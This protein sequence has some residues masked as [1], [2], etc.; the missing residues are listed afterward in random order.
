MNL[1]TKLAEKPIKAKRKRIINA[2]ECEHEL[3]DVLIILFDVFHQAV[4]K[5]NKEIQ[6]TPP[7]ARP[8]GFEAGLLN[9]KFVQCMQNS[10][11]EDWRR[12]K[13]G[14]IMLYK[15]GYIIFF[16]KLNNKDMPMNIRTKMT[17]SIENQEQGTL[18]HDDDDVKAPILFF[19]YKKNRFG[20]I[21]DPKIV[22]IDEGRVK[23]NITENGMGHLKRTTVV[24]PQF[25]VAHVRVKGQAKSK[26]GTNDD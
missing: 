26:T 13:Y 6:Q 23:W 25:P 16:K 24:L 14:R 3:R 12:G 18:F 11:S 10:F 15:N 4:E 9:A 5:F 7:D 19:G 20:E 1:K 21:V 17:D 2:K 8:R 22:Y